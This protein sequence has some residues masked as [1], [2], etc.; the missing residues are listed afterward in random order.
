M[1]DA[2]TTTPL[3]IAVLGIGMMGRPIARRLKEAGHQVQVWNRTRA[4]AEPLAAF[5]ITVH[6]SPTEAVQNADMVISLLENGPVVGHVLFES[7]A[8]K[9]M[10]KGALFIDMASI[11][12]REARDH[13]ARLGE[14]GLA[15]L[16]APVSGGTVGAENG[17][18]AILVG[19]RPEDFAQAQPVF[20][21]CGR[22]THVGPHGAGQLTKLANQM[23]VGITIG[24]VAEALLFAAKGGADMAKVREAIQ[25]GFAD[26]RILQLHGQRMVER[27]FAPRGRMAVQ[28]KDMRNAL[29]TAG[30]IGFDAPIT[31][32]FETLYAEGVDHGLGELD[33]SGLFV[34]L[35]SRNAMQ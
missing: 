13:A 14:M 4:K 7:G 31:A 25:G 2:M 16:D 20:A 19:G 21:A 15:H 22:A 10:R 26:S 12:P 32:L 24:A 23:I 9:A 6:A 27:D 30:E 29:A 17:T 33:H 1:N 5:G 3:R 11:Q 34:E 18:L 28:L 35:A 8:A